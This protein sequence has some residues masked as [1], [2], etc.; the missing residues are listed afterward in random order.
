M[1]NPIEYAKRELTLLRGGDTA[2]DEVLDRIDAHILKMIEVFAAEGHGN[3]SAKFVIHCLTRLLRFL[4]LTPL[5]GEEDEWNERGVDIFSGKPRP[6]QNKR[7]FSV[8][9]DDGGAYNIEGKLFSSD[10]KTWHI[11]KD[12]RV[13]IEF[14]YSVPDKPEYILISSQAE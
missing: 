2:P 12:S 5:T 7:C 6:L 1:S 3:T 13:Y 10:D 14:P 9:K 8:F 4:P 11:N